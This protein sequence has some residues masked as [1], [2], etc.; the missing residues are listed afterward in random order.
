[1]PDSSSL[2]NAGPVDAEQTQ[3]VSAPTPP[4][5]GELVHANA[6][7]LLAGMLGSAPSCGEQEGDVIGPYRLCELLGE[8]G[9]GNVW[10]A[11][12][13]HVVK[14]EVALKLIKPGMD[15]AQVLGRFN[16]ERQALAS[17]RHPNIATLLDAG[18]GP[19]GRPYFAMELVHGGPVTDWCKAGDVPLQERLRLFIQICHAVQHAHEKG[20]LHRDIKPTNILVADINGQ[21]VPKVID[22]GVA[23]ALNASSLEELTL[24]TQADQAVGMPLYMSPEQIQGGRELDA[25]SDVYALGVV[26]YELL[27][28]SLPFDST[29]AAVRGGMDGLKR[30]IL[31]TLPERPSTR[32]RRRTSTGTQPRKTKKGFEASLSMLPADLDW[33]TMRALEKDRQRRYPTAAEFAAD[34]QRHL[35]CQPVLARPPS[36]SYKAGRWMRRNRTTGFMVAAALASGAIVAVWHRIPVPES[37]SPQAQRSIASSSSFKSPP[38]QTAEEVPKP[39]HTN[40]L[41]M[42]FIPV[43]GTEVLFCIHETRFKDFAAYA[44]EVPGADGAWKNDL[45]PGIGLPQ[46]DRL[47]HPATRVDWTEAQAFCQWLSK[48]EGR[49]YRLPTDREW[50]YAVGVGDAEK[51]TPETTPETAVKSASAYPWGEAWPPPAGAGNYGDE[52]WKRVY[53]G[54]VKYRNF[55]DEAW[56][57][58]SATSHEPWIRGYD[59]GFALTAPVMS[60][61]PNKLGLYDLGGNVAEW[62][63][64]WRTPAQKERVL[65]GD[66]WVFG[67]SPNFRRNLLSSTRIYRPYTTPLG[68]NVG[69][70]FRCVLEH[71]TLETNPMP[72][73]QAAIAPGAKLLDPGKVAHKMTTSQALPATVTNTLGMKFLPVPGTDVL[74]CIH[75]TRQQDYAAYAAAVPGV[76]DHWKRPMEGRRLGDDYPVSYI[77]QDDAQQFSAW[78]GRKEGKTYRLPTDHEW[79]LAV[80]LDEEAPLTHE[81]LQAGPLNTTHYPWNGRFPPEDRDGNYAGKEWLDL[82]GRYHSK[83]QLSGCNDGFLVAAPV[84]SFR[85]NPFGLYDMGGNLAELCVFPPDAE[86]KR[87]EVLRGATFSTDTTPENL[88][89]SC[90]VWPKFPLPRGVPFGFRVVL[91]AG[92]EAASASGSSRVQSAQVPGFEQR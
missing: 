71:H 34:V 27:T 13:T 25:R 11:E 86:G 22:F 3:A 80:G 55:V 70:G 20:I 43:P 87:T 75:E 41:G 54:N 50:S 7:R 84:M 85:A 64:D 56:R 73:D 68:R 53:D 40:S 46:G 69:Y 36:V 61:T 72:S 23:K 58:S 83:A 29:S 17:L 12:Q 10:H 14:R 66:F 26:L 44:A 60:F 62:V 4:T 42:Q 8:G 52:A 32:V 31:D 5:P 16:Q 90:R 21:P 82:G 78:L 48:K 63:A 89:S 49:T 76:S 77:N 6:G 9:F 47:S 24:L 15:S 28:G 74:F 1:M 57:R 2:D 65:R 35:D 38:P 79:S 39:T 92:S 45:M 81:T 67:G 59:D 18:V 33:I 51:W 19:N 30:M 91:E 37:P 88:L